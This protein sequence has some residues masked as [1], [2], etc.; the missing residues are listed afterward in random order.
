[1]QIIPPPL[2]PNNRKYIVVVDNEEYPRPAQNQVYQITL[3]SIFS[4]N[5]QDLGLPDFSTLKLHDV[6]VLSKDKS[7]YT[8]AIAL[9]KNEFASYASTLSQV[10][11]ALS[12]TSFTYK[13]HEKVDNNSSTAVNAKAGAK[14]GSVSVHF[15]QKLRQVSEALMEVEFKGQPNGIPDTARANDILLESEFADDSAATALISMVNASSGS[16][17]QEFKWKSSRIETVVRE[18]EAAINAAYM[19]F[20]LE[21]DA[22]RLSS[23][24]SELNLEVTFKFN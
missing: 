24:A 11:Q 7:S 15:E 13:A 21:G 6:L 8:N 12:C 23:M 14:G 10:A 16:L 4:D 18:Y 20:K 22:E 5:C 3:D 9:A 1:M 17:A 2:D 19:L